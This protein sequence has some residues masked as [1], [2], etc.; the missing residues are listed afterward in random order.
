MMRF[1]NTLKP[2]SDIKNIGLAFRAGLVV[3]GEKAVLSEISKMR[4]IFL[5][6]DAGANI[7]KKIHDKCTFYNIPMRHDLDKSILSKAI[8]KSV[9]VIG[10]KDTGFRDLLL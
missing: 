9:T 4:L 3:F 1:M 5:A 8:S 10:I 2:T 6:S 7:T